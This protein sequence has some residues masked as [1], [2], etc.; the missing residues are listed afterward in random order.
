M[1]INCI[2]ALGE[3]N[4]P[5]QAIKLIKENNIVINII[6][7]SHFDDLA[8]KKLS[9]QLD[10]FILSKKISNEEIIHF[11][12]YEATQKLIC[13][14]LLSNRNFRTVGKEPQ[15]SLLYKRN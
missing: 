5:V 6:C 12:K 2:A 8:L 9:T 13:P 14:P 11:I 1:V 7:A 10:A 15:N 3:E 4:I